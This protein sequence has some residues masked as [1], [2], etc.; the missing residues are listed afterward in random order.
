M[1]GS[2]RPDSAMIRRPSATSGGSG[3]VM[4]SWLLGQSAGQSWCLWPGPSMSMSAQKPGKDREMSARRGGRAA[5]CG[6]WW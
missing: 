6:P 1:V 5:G 3:R 2:G 4:W